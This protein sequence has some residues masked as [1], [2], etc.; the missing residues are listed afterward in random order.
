MAGGRGVATSMRK[1]RGASLPAAVQGVVVSNGGPDG[2][3]FSGVLAYQCLF[4]AK[5]GG[6]APGMRPDDGTKAT[7]P[8]P[9][10]AF[11]RLPSPSV[12]SRHKFFF[13]RKRDGT[14]GTDRT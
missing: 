9:S 12:A 11:R 4:S 7:V 2:R 14:D 1:R 13:T 10:V 8:S 6:E 3:L 5:A